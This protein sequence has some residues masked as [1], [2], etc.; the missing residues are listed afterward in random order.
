MKNSANNCN[1][2]FIEVVQSRRNRCNCHSAVYAIRDGVQQGVEV[3]PDEVGI[4]VSLFF[5]R[6]R[7]T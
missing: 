3:D 4:A 2:T 5:F 7:A 1:G 6:I